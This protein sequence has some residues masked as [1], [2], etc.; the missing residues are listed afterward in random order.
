MRDRPLD[1]RHE[2]QIQRH[3]MI[4]HGDRHNPAVPGG[5]KILRVANIILPSVAGEH[6][7]WL[8]WMSRS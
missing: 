3:N 1:P 7:K 6:S 4:G 5:H 2:Q 8:E